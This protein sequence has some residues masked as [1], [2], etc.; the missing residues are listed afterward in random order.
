MRS[1]E[2]LYYFGRGEVVM[3]D[4]GTISEHT[5]VD[6]FSR[7]TIRFYGKRADNVLGTLKLSDNAPLLITLTI[8]WRQ[9]G[10]RWKPIPIS[11]E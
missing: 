10:G 4:G 9:Y 2:K 7:E 11:A 5:C 6:P 1:K 3:K 8:E